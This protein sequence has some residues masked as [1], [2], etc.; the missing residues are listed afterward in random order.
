MKNIRVVLRNPT[1]K[2]K[3]IDYTI[4]V[5][6]TELSRDWLTALELDIVKPNLNLEKNFCFLGFPY[7]ARTVEYLCNELNQHCREI[8]LFNN[9]ETWQNAGLEPYVIEEWFTEQSV[10]FDSSYPIAPP[11]GVKSFDGDPRYLGLKIKHN[12]MNVLHNH[13]ERLQGTVWEPSPYYALATPR[14]KHAIRNLNLIC[15]ELESL[16]LSQRKI[17]QSPSWVRPSQI[18]AFV[19][20]PRHE[21][22]DSHRSLFKNGYDKK[23]G[24]VYMH[25]TQI[26]KTLMEVYNDEG[27]PDLTVGNDPTDISVG[28][29]TTCE[30]INALK[31]YSG[32]FD[33][34]WGKSVTYNEHHWHREYIDNFYAW[35]T[36]NG[37]D[38][39]NPKLSLGYLPI[40]SVDLQSS[41]GTTSAQEIWK[42]LGNYL[43]IYQ[44]EVNGVVATYDYSWNDADYQQK[45][46]DLLR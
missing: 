10:R 5:H 45:Q 25:W 16:I 7:T 34:E 13:F 14:V 26:G 15:H 30:A 44:I 6:D 18:T 17:V 36:R 33:I 32:E 38:Y 4:T 20:V 40:A 46:I 29:G 9:T 22:K 24:E 19:N 27:A 28:A 21:L 41:F 35:L 8:N 42:T 3:K 1:N 39:T 31:F 23:F 11:P 37:V 43:D 12:I 2:N